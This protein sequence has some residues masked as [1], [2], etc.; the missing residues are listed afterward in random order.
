MGGIKYIFL[1]H[2]DDVADADRYAEKF[3]AVRIIHQADAQAVPDAEWVVKGYDRVQVAPEFQ[4]IPVPGHTS[5]SMALLYRDL[6]LFTG[7]HL[8]WD[9]DTKSLDMPSV[10]VWDK[11][12]L[13]QSTQHLLE[14]SFKWVLPGHGDRIRLSPLQMK[15]ELDRLLQRRGVAD[16]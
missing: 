4:V 6:F 14:C 3:N 8:W 10:L 2:E 11:K 12:R 5:G 15:I 16:S 9:R 13:L 1:S 7:D